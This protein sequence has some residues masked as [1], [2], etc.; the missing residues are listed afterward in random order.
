MSSERV[1]SRMFIRY[2]QQVIR[3]ER[4]NIHRKHLKDTK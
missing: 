1:G 4:I 3:N 2:I